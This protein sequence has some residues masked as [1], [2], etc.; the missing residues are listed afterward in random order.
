MA[1]INYLNLLFEGGAPW[2][3]AIPLKGL[4]T[5]GFDVTVSKTMLTL[6][7]ITT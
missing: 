4:M 7:K 6:I 5:V 3:V 2:M 1:L